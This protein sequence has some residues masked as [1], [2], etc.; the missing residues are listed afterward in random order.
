MRPS[1]RGVSTTIIGHAQT[2]STVAGIAINSATMAINASTIS[3]PMITTLPDYNPDQIP[4]LVRIAIMEGLQLL[5]P[6]HTLSLAPKSVLCCRRY[7][8][9]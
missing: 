3:A 1:K 2:V 8:S 6:F 5:P 9:I 4:K 7:S